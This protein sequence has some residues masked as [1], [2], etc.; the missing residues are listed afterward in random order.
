MSCL[1]VLGALYKCHVCVFW[2]HYI[3]RKLFSATLHLSCIYMFII[4]FV[5]FQD[6]LGARSEGSNPLLAGG[7]RCGLSER[8]R[9]E[10]EHPG[11]DV[12]STSAVPSI[13]E[14]TLD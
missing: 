14:K 7:G 3:T 10:H 12:I 8:P 2:E 6:P 11:N 9:D 13:L 4:F 5:V 1:C